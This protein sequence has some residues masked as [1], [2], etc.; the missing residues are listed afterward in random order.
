MG[1]R[2]IVVG[3][4]GSETA[5][6]AVDKAVRFAKEVDGTIV[7][8]C[9]S[10][11]VGLTDDRAE[12]VLEA[13]SDRVRRSEVAVD[14]VVREGAPEDVI[15]A[16]ANERDADLVVVG[17]VGMGKAKRLSLGPI[18]ERVIK[19]SPADVL[20]VQTQQERP[21]DPDRHGLYG[22]IVVGTDGS[23]TASEAARK[24][25]D[26]GMMLGVGV[27][28]VYVAGDELLGAIALERTQKAKPRALGVE[29]RVEHGEPAQQLAKVTAEQDD[30][31]VVVGNKGMTGARKVLLGSVPLQVAHGAPGDVLIA[32]T[33]DRTIADLAPGTGGLVNVG[34]R[35]LAVY[36]AEDDS[37]VALSPRCSHMGCT[38]DWNPADATWDCPCHGSR[39]AKD[40]DVIQGP[41]K[42]PLDPAD[43]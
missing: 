32:K 20:L 2:T 7:L 37:I 18:P 25:Y 26:L 15:P 42:A 1:Y 6:R 38:V 33:V 35:R 23:S 36:K 3:T 13:A 19:D 10:A 22:R 27:T 14:A 4:D 12:A 43:A 9:A 39:Y 28:L 8:V 21:V 31:L 24:A 29:T 5:T 11:P 41:S 17:N 40:G 30:G 16:V 34:G